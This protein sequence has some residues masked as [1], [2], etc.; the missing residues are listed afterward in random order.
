MTWQA[1]L[2][3][4]LFLGLVVVCAKPLGIYDAARSAPAP[5]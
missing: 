5:R 2:Q 3:Y 1:F 4:A